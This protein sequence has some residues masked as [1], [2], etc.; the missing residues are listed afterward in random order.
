M[1]MYSRD[2]NKTS[3]FLCIVEMQDIRIEP[4][5]T[6]L[7]ICPKDEY[8]WIL[9]AYEM[10]VNVYV[11][12]I[13]FSSFRMNGANPVHILD[14]EIGK[15]LILSSRLDCA[16]GQVLIEARVQNVVE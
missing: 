10:T 15:W 5:V 3:S 9:P 6:Y 1:S 8:C 13:P 4:V 14:T 16:S 12:G 7:H 11:K 2:D